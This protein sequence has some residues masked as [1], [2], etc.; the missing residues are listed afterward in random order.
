MKWLIIAW[1]MSLW[2]TA[3][4]PAQIPADLV[5]F[6]KKILNEKLHFLYSEMSE[7]VSSVQKQ[8]T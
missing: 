7:G 1:L 8:T 6:T 3:Q 2:N 4:I 5:T